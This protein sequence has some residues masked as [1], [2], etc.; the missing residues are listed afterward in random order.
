MSEPRV[1]RRPVLLLLLV[2]MLALECAAL[3]AA[4]CY[5]LVELLV[6]R[7]DSYASA[8]AILVL[9][10]L[11][12]VWIGV[13]AAHALRGRSWIRGG[14]ITWQVLQIAIGIGS[15]PGTFS[16]PDIGWALVIPAAIVLVLLFTP[17][18]IDATRR[19]DGE[20]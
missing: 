8:V 10:V 11:A 12:A 1:S 5:L 2:A 13:M 19:G 3:V 17:P 14:A 16:R 20:D 6:A 7:P 4:A 15:F 9:V 18:V